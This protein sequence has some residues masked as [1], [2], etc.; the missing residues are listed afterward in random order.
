MRWPLD[1]RTGWPVGDAAVFLDLSAQDFG[2]DGAVIDAA[3]NL[4]N[5]QWGA[6]RVACY[7]PTG[8]YVTEVR[9]PTP[10][11]SCPAFGGPDLSTLFITTAADGLPDDPL[12]GQTF[13]TPTAH[14]G[15]AEHQVIL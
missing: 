9:V 13:A 7:D 6:G 15:Q 4:W 1:A 8:A 12:A 5:A 3:G 11:A 2:A 14:R 10:Q